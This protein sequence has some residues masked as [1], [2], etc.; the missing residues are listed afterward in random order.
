V[1]ITGYCN[2]CKVSWQAG[3]ICFPDPERDIGLLDRYREALEEIRDQ[4]SIENT[5]DPQWAA[6]IARAALRSRGV[7][8]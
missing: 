2:R 5:L 7:D 6:R 1:T 3:H 8:P 4:D